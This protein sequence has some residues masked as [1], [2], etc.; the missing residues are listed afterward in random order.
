MK[1]R[2]LSLFLALVMV[3]SVLPVNTLANGA[4]GSTETAVLTVD[5]ISAKASE[6]VEIS[7]N[8]ENNPGILGATFTLTWDSMLS[9]TDYEVGEVFSELTLVKPSQLISGCNFVWYGNEI[10]NITDGKV[11]TL[12][13]KVSAQA[14][15]GDALDVNVSYVSGDVVDK[16]YEPVELNIV[17]G[18]VEVISYI[19][20][21]VNDDGRIN[22][23]DLI[24]LSQYISDS[25]RTNPDGY[26]AVVNIAASDVNDDTRLNPLDLIM[27][28]QYISDG[29]KTD[30]DGYNVTLKPSTPRCDHTTVKTQAVGATCTEEGNIEYWSC[31]KCNKLF[32][33]ENAK[34]EIKVSETVISPLGHTEVIDEAVSP[35]Y[36]ETGLTEGKHCSVCHEVLVAQEVVP[37]KTCSHIMNEI[38]EKA[39]T[40]T[41]AGNTA[42][43]Y[44]SECTRYFADESAT[45][46]IDLDDTVISA[47]GHTEVTDDAVEP[48]YTQTG[49]TEGKHC[50]VC[51]KV[52][53]AQEIVPVKTC[54]HTMNHIPALK[55]TCTED[56]NTEYWYC[57]SC[58]R[59]FGNANGGKAIAISDT[60]LPATGHTEV[61]DEAVAPTYT[62]TGLTEGK[63]CSVC[64]EVLVAQEIVPVKVCAHTMQNTP[65]KAS[66]CTEKGNISY[67]YCSACNRYYTAADG[68][69]E[70][71]LADTVTPAKGHIEVIDEAVAP[72]YTETG[73]TEGKHCSVC[74]EILVAQVVVPVKTCTHTLTSVPAKAS[75]CTEEGNVAYWVCGNCEKL[76][77]DSKAKTE[78]EIEDTVIDAKGHEYSTEWFHDETHH[79]HPAICG[80]ND[81]TGKT[82]HTFNSKNVCIVC[83]YFNDQRVKLDTP[84][85]TSVSNDTINWTAVT[86]APA[87][88]VEYEV[89][90]EDYSYTTT[91]TSISISML[92]DKYGRTI[93]QNMFEEAEENLSAKVLR[94]IQVRA[95]GDE[96]EY[97]HSEWSDPKSGYRYVPN[98]TSAD[99]K[100]LEKYKIG[101]G[102][103]LVTKGYLNVA[104]ASK[105]SVLDVAKLLTLA[106]YTTPDISEPSTSTYYSYSSVDEYMANMEE[107]LALKA[108]IEIPLAGSLNAEL[109]A[110]N[111]SSFKDYSYNQMFVAEVNHYA[112]DHNLSNLS[113]QD[114]KDAVSF[115]FLNVLNKTAEETAGMTDE[116]LARHI[117]GTYGTHVIL[118]VRTGALLRAQYS[119]STN[120]EEIASS[121]MTAFKVGGSF[122]FAG[123]VKLNVGV[124]GEL[125]EDETRKSSDT[126]TKFNVEWLGSTAGAV[127]DPANLDAALNAWS[128]G[129]DP[130]PLSFSEDGAISMV[131]LLEVVAPE[132][133][134]EFEAIMVTEAGNAYDNLCKLYDKQ[135]ARLV[136]MPEEIGGKNVITVDL[137]AYQS[138]ASLENAYDPN[139]IDGILTFYP[140]MYGKYV[141]KIVIK[142]NFSEHKTLIDSMTLKLDGNW[143]RPLDIVFENIGITATSDCGL[144]DLSALD[145]PTLVN[146]SYDD[147]CIEK[148]TEGVIYYHVN[149]Y[150]KCYDFKLALNEGEILDI[151]NARLDS[152]IYLPLV[153]VP[154]YDFGGW[155]I[156]EI[157]IT[158]GIVDV[159]PGKLNDGY[160]PAVDMPTLTAKWDNATY[161]I[162][163][164]SNTADKSD[165]TTAIRQVYSTG[166]TDA[167]KN[168][169]TSITIPEKTGYIFEGYYTSDNTE[170]I[171]NEG[172]ITASSVTFSE[173]RNITLKAKWREAVYK[174][175]LDGNSPTTAGTS[176]I[177]VKY[178]TGFYSDPQCKTETEIKSVTTPKKNAHSFAGF[179]L[180]TTQY[181]DA[182]GKIIAT[183]KTFNEANVSKDTSGATDG[184]VTFTAGWSKNTVINLSASSAT[185]TD[186]TQTIYLK[187][188]TGKVY[189]DVNCTT[190]IKRITMPAKTGYTYG[191]YYNGSTCYINADGTFNTANVKTLFK[192]GANV[193]LTSNMSVNSYTIEYN[194]NKPSNATSSVTG[195]PTTTT[196]CYYNSNVTL[197]SAPSLKGWKFEGWYNESGAKVGNGSAILTKPNLSSKNG[198]IVK[199]YAKWTATTYTV[200]FN[201]NTSSSDESFKCCTAPSPLSY[202]SKTVA[203]DSQ[204]TL[205]VP[206]ANYYIFAG[207]YTSSKGGTQVTDE[208]GKLLNGGKWNIME[209]TTLYAHWDKKYVNYTYVPNATAFKQISQYGYYM[210]VNDIDLNGVSF[211]LKE[212]SG[213]LNG[214]GHTISNWKMQQTSSGNY[215]IFGINSGAL[216]HIN[217]SNCS[218]TNN[219]PMASGTLN[220]GILCGINKGD[221][222]QVVARNC[223][224]TVDL[225]DIAL[226]QSSYVRAGIICGYNTS[227]TG[228]IYNSG[229]TKCSITANA[230]TKE[231]DAY[232][233]VGGVVGYSDGGKLQDVFAN[234]FDNTNGKKIHAFVSADAYKEGGIFGTHYHGRPYAYVGG[235]VGY[236]KSTILNRVIG[237]D[238]AISIE[239]TR[240]C[241][242]DTNTEIAQG[243]LAGKRESCTFTHCYSENGD[244]LFGVTDSTSGAYKIGDTMILDQLKTKSSYFNSNGWSQSTGTGEHPTIKVEVSY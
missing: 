16:N 128:A 110:S 212:F 230:V 36:T 133:V 84:Q 75:S 157:V 188:D 29:C 73:L 111:S 199:L 21:D 49:L 224:V 228:T 240:N 94:N 130:V 119:V 116:A 113:N 123:V 64:S 67:W 24:K 147:I 151:T 215:G 202:S 182:S 204:Y 170:I 13:F 58:D 195:M 159:N 17:N 234:G 174:I 59:Y 10:T 5:T 61:I 1:T 169:I 163:L 158:D 229:A 178:G 105:Y 90:V 7:V 180:G 136:N 98:S 166:F 45:E 241:G 193:T 150:N 121:A 208:Y 122:D 192:A 146:V 39:P 214:K 101:Y 104:D 141:D 152:G 148:D 27:L 71:T 52:L 28:S 46:E 30:P 236:C 9:L 78:I 181:I 220:A 143:N 160:T 77:S 213:L 164:D 243:S 222:E 235:V 108:G 37:V 19:P 120:S 145:N 81:I 70:I 3:I 117:Y 139:F 137:S 66:T 53:V 97:I 60:H 12:K 56:G 89:V 175:V 88:C 8:I 103:N 62:E 82:V 173:E 132:L 227:S 22:P 186:R 34:S 237:H 167:E 225:G 93:A 31:T 95:I 189:S 187:D 85:I 233:Y 41:E 25:G 172:E 11:L 114:I 194:A 6:E 102:Y 112:D 125:K 168:K 156:G 126:E 140:K 15:S 33:D 79:W 138:S 162:T 231:E 196:K 161:Y 65:A 198:D 134:D 63:H 48:T 35:T 191:G 205:S 18:G 190:E 127:T 218:I 217:L 207:W 142:G 4:S 221:I 129:V 44:C 96:D 47:L 153:T 200:S 106:T 165:G 155:E 183:A 223:S 176:A 72:T 179:Y 209:N 54:T 135:L 242:H 99:K 32:E 50:S 118:G 51:Q 239:R 86:N 74:S 201:L 57:T 232:A 177:Y 14:E 206:G 80:H 42:Y 69:T 219:N 171:N 144:V 92:R 43:W 100:L 91:N 226:S 149:A 203:Y 244:T 210:L 2:F 115:D 216:L 131:S 38:A 238:N 68:A 55:A 154:G 87:N 40:C 211:H 109:S 107:K 26:N 184:T 124:E 76:F 20:G 185:N 197:A 83:S 23:L